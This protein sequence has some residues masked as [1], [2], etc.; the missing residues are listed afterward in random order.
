MDRA[1]EPQLDR[2][3]V[4]ADHR[5]E[6]RD[7]VADH[8]FGRVV[9]QHREPAAA[10]EPRR[11]QPRQRL[12]QQAMLRNGKDVRALGLAV[13]ARHPRQTVGDVFQ[14]DVERRRIEQVEPAPRQ[15]ALPGARLR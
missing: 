11:A 1:E 5:L 10:I 13:P 8:V 2:L 9:Q 7:H 6:R 3:V 14:L 12:D 4:A 15:H